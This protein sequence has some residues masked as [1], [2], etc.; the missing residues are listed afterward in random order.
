MYAFSFCLYNSYNPYYYDGLLENLTLIHQHFP[1]WTTFIYVG[2]DV[3]ES[4]VDRVRSMSNTVIRITGVR[5]EENMV[6]RFFA[7]DE[8]DVEYMFVRDADSRIHWKDRWAIRA[9][10]KTD[11][12]LHVIRDSPVH[13]APIMGGLWGMKKVNNV[14]VQS[15]YDDHVQRAPSIQCRGLDQRFLIDCVY[16]RFAES[17]VIHSSQSW[18]YVPSEQ[19]IPFPFEY[20]TSIYC[21]RVETPIY[22]GFEATR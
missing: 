18:T 6:H 17:V 9:F 3:P 11:A 16:P 12:I 19:L 20:K 15:L 14:C 21:G 4:F 22:P 1:T 10:L 7:I 13:T 2:N 8:P 5:G